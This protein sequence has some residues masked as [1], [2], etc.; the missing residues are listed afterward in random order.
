LAAERDP[1]EDLVKGEHD[2]SMGER[3]GF[4]FWDL[5]KTWGPALLTV[6]VIRSVVAEPF[7]IPSGSM[8]PTLAIGDYIIVNKFSY[9]IRVP[10][11]KYKLIPM[12]DPQ[13]GE[14]IVFKYPEDPS[15]DYIKRVVAIP[16]DE[17]MVR[18]N[19]LYVNGEK[20]PKRF[21][22]S[23]EFIDDHCRHEGAKLF[24]ETLD[25]REHEVLNSVGFGMPFSDYGPETVPPS[26]VF[27]MGDNRDNSSDSRRWGGVPFDYIKG[28]ALVVWLSY[29]RCSGGPLHLGS[30]RFDR[31]GTMLH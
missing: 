4:W 1:L 17:V 24:I 20:Q 15:L 8:V 2:H 30:L 25:G 28:K 13:R 7:R 19:V 26:Q 18:D 14:I 6:L 3:V 31:F 5:L 23:Y 9:G 29:D 11:T 12:D 22:D 21:V 10:F 16:G 27:V